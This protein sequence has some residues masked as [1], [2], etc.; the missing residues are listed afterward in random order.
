VQFTTSEA[1]IYK[2]G[3]LFFSHLKK[4]QRS[5]SVL[6]HL[7]PFEYLLKDVSVQLNNL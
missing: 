1:L 4:E 7:N 3:N 6:S 2:S 5:A